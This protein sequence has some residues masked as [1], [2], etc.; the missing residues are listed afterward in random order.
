[1]MQS[2]K[3]LFF[4]GSA[5]GESLNQRLAQLAAR[6]A[7]ANGIPVTLAD[8]LDYPLPLPAAIWNV[9]TA[10][11]RMARK[12]K[13]LMQAHSGIF[14]AAPEYN[15]SLTPLLKNTLDWESRVKDEGKPPLHVFK[16]RVFAIASAAAGQFGGM[17]GL[18]A[19]HQVLTAGLSALVLPIQVSV[20]LAAAAFN[21]NGHLK[22][23][24]QQELLKSAISELARLAKVF[25][26]P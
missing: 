11:R 10:S 5:R 2:E 12:L 6:I 4:S 3:L 18:I 9:T 24:T 13:A 23:K 22:D 1:M 14:I 20:P 26:G 16:T 19:L 8:L 21:E 15:A 7:E 17:R 25:H